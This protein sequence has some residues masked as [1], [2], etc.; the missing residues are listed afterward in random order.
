MYIKF[1]KHIELTHEQHK[2]E[3]HESTFTRMF[4]SNKSYSTTQSEVGQI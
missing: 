3:L 2:F 4:F 1:I